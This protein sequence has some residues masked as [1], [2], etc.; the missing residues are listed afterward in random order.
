MALDDAEFGAGGFLFREGNIH[1]HGA[2]RHC[3]ITK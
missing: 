3:H 2:A 1:D